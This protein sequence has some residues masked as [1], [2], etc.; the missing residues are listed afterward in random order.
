MA[1]RVADAH[2]DLQVDLKI[3]KQ[4]TLGLCFHFAIGIMHTPTEVTK[5]LL[6]H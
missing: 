1:R 6:E 3:F 2:A 5:D 4:L